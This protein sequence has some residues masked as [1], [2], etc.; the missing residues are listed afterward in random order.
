MPGDR[1]RE[2]EDAAIARQRPFRILPVPNAKP[3]SV[4][5]PYD[6]QAEEAQVFNFVAA[7]SPASTYGG[8]NDFESAARSAIYM[9]S[10]L[11]AIVNES[12]PIE[13]RAG[14]TASMLANLDYLLTQFSTFATNTIRYGAIGVVGDIAYSSRATLAGLAFIKGYLATGDYELLG[15]AG[16]C[17]TFL[18]SMQAVYDVAGGV[19]E[20][21]DTNTVALSTSYKLSDVMALW[22]L[23]ELAEEVGDDAVYGIAAPEDATPT[24][25]TIGT[26][27]SRLTTF[28]VT[29][30]V[31]STTGENVTGLS[32]ATPKATYVYDQVSSGSWATITDIASVD[33]AM[34]LRGLYEADPDAEIIETMV[35]WFAAFT[36]NSANA[37]PSTNTEQQTLDG[38]T[39]DYDPAI[40]PA[41]S[42]T[43]VAP[44]TES[45]GAMYDLQSIGLLAPVLAASDADGL[46]D[47]RADLSPGQRFS[48]F[49]LNL[50]YL[51]P[52]GR[53]GL[54]L[55]P[56]SSASS[57]T[58]NT[59]LAADFAAVYRYV[60]P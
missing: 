35:E 41:T 20:S 59:G 60:N 34:A 52:L 13:W 19:A 11:G 33:I 48:T 53:A 2:E 28:A 9:A 44:F 30:P 45:A 4:D 12:R 32:A 24:D 15:A 43:A 17:A 25:Q 5:S 14:A 1:I 56:R 42:L 10:V 22:F 8:A 38:I 18:S 29:G 40:C 3:L 49:D 21:L 46:R 54:S 47:S 55:Q 51:G 26:M 57:I 27:I 39:G 58:P 37:T 16:K 36:A 7:V 50:R 31:D 23:S 6:W